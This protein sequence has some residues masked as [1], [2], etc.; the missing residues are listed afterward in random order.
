MVPLPSAVGPLQGTTPSLR[1]VRRGGPLS[2]A[3][4][5]LD[6]E[7]GRALDEEH[8]DLPVGLR[9]VLRVRRG[10]RDGPPPTEPPSLTPCLARGPRPRPRARP[11]PPLAGGRRG[12]GLP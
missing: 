3:D 11:D 12:G 7:A 1:G 5:A 10:G 8:R 2:A 4:V 9:L 6:L